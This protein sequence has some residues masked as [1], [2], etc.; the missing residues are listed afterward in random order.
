MPASD[1]RFLECARAGFEQIRGRLVELN[2]VVDEDHPYL[3][4]TLDIPEQRGLA[5]PIHAN[6]QND[7]EIH[8]ECCGASLCWFPCS[9]PDNV[10]DF[11]E[12]VVGLVQGTCRIV[13]KLRGG[14]VRTA[15]VEVNQGG[16]WAKKSPGIWHFRLPRIFPSETRIVQNEAGGLA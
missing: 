2:V 1:A 16:D 9:Q 8:L 7:D 11:V 14:A 4:L 15:R 6:L 3:D 5:F 13:Q 12:T 10:D